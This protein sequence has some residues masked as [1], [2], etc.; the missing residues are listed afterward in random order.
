VIVV[1]RCSS[2]VLLVIAALAVRPTLP[3]DVPSISLLA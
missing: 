3:R 1:Q 2:L